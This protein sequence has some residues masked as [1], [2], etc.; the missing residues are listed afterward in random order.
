MSARLVIVSSCLLLGMVTGAAAQQPA[1]QP[2]A[3]ESRRAIEPMLLSE[4]QDRELDVWLSAMETWQRYDARWDNRPIHDGWGRIAE[5]KASPI[6]PEW[7]LGYCTSVAATGLV[8]F[9]ERTSTAC[10]LAADPRAK[11]T[12]VP[13]GAQAAALDAESSLKSNFMRRIHLDGL[14]TTTSTQGRLYG[15]VGSHLS[16][17]DIGRLQVFGPP[18]VILLSVPDTDGSRQITLGY[19]WGVSV[20]LADMRFLDRDMTLFANVTKLWV[21]SGEGATASMRGFDAVGFSIAPRRKR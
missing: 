7:L 5:R 1:T 10:R 9:D 11:M 12:A 20:R 19:T 18:G 8:D 6:Y 16:L 3:A 2:P 15:L 17:V 14:W 13:T 21:N 4:D